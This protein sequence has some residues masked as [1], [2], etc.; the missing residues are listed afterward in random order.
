[1]SKKILTLVLASVL[2]F[3][4]FSVSVFAAEE[5]HGDHQQPARCGRHGPQRCAR[6][7]DGRSFA[8]KFQ[9]L[10]RQH[11][12]AGDPVVPRGQAF[13]LHRRRERRRRDVG[14]FRN[15]SAAASGDAGMFI[16]AIFFVRLEQIRKEVSLPG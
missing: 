10:W 12:G 5:S 11:G 7:H 13:L 3:C 9:G 6:I 1:M 2:V 15:G 8:G 14:L 16:A 4:M